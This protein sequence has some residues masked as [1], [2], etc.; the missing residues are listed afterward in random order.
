MSSIHRKVIFVE[1]KDDHEALEYIFKGENL[2][3][4]PLGGSQHVIEMF[5][6]LADINSHIYD[7]K[8]VFLVDSD[9]KPEDFFDNIRSKNTKFYDASFIKMNCHELEN[10]FLD[11][12]LFLEKINEYLSVSDVNR[13]DITFE[14]I[15]NKI[16]E[17]ARDTQHATYKKEISLHL[18]HVVDKNFSDRIWEVAHLTFHLKRLHLKKFHR[19]LFLYLGC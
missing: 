4:K 17:I 8:F 3:I 15:D 9:N 10:Y 13:P 7:M 12:R 5:S 11:P 19:Q 1:G 2:I 14:S 16:V 6:K 18:Q